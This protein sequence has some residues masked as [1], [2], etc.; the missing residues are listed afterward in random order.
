MGMVDRVLR[1]ALAVV[2]AILYF[3]GA[4]SGTVAIIL[5][6]IAVIFLVTGLVG[7]CP[8]YML[9]GISTSKNK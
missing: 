2:V 4:I 9:F 3:A 6:I 8:L 5:G 1:L 7:V